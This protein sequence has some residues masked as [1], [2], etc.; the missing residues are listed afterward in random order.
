M[1]LFNFIQNCIEKIYP[2]FVARI[3]AFLLDNKVQNL[4]FLPTKDGLFLAQL[5]KALKEKLNLLVR[6]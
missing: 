1:K 4:I 2:F 3:P 6:H 5:S